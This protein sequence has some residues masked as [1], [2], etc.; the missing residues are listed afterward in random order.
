MPSDEGEGSQDMARALYEEGVAVL[1]EARRLRDE[2]LLSRAV[3][4]LRRCA[5]AAD[6]RVARC[7]RWTWR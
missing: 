2:R 1:E 6:T 7:R 3:G 4:L 5:D